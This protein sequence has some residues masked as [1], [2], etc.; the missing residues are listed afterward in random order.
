MTDHSHPVSPELSPE[1]KARIKNKGLDRPRT[2]RA[3][4]QLSSCISLGIFDRG[5]GDNK[6]QFQSKHP[7]ELWGRR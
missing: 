1:V 4:R 5:S 6:M 7:S 3:A 2:E